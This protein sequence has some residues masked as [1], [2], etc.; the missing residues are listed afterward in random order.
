MILH[1]YFHLA[2]RESEDGLTTLARWRLALPSFDAAG[3]PRFC[4]WDWFYRR[5]GL[6]SCSA[7]PSREGFWYVFGA[8]IDVQVLF[9]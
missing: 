7:L 3:L 8:S 4:R 5:F 6:V 9:R 1:R 2:F